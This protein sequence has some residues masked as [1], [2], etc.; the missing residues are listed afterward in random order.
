MGE[1]LKRVE[2]NSSVVQGT[3]EGF[4]WA[5]RVGKK[6][7]QIKRENLRPQ[8]SGKKP[9]RTKTQKTD[10]KSHLKKGEFC[11]EAATNRRTRKNQ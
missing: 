9:K 8:Q 5:Q 4:K 6:K 2:K 7:A 10:R 3:Q 1:I 11:G